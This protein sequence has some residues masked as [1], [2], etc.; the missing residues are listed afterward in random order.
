VVWFLV[1]IYVSNATFN[2]GVLNIHN[3]EIECLMA[4]EAMIAY[5]GRE[6]LNYNVVCIKTDQIKGTAF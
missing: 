3:T 6:K 4:S 1:G 2:F 5:V